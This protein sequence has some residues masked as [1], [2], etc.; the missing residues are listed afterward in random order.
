MSFFSLE[1]SS[2]PVSPLNLFVWLKFVLNVFA[3]IERALRVGLVSDVVPDDKLD[4]AAKKL[5]LNML[6]TSR[7]VWDA[8][9]S[10]SFISFPF[11]GP[12]YPSLRSRSS[13]SFGFFSPS[14]NNNNNNNNN[15]FG[16]AW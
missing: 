5:A 1:T 4:E 2:M 8:F 6:D 16:R 11:F 12:S 9:F 15:A 10:P 13:F 3:F 14:P 7:K